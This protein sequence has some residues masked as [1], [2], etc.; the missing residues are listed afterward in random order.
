MYTGSVHLWCFAVAIFNLADIS[1]LFEDDDLTNEQRTKYL[2]FILNN[3]FSELF[4]TSNC[5]ISFYEIEDNY[6]GLFNFNNQSDFPQISSI[7]DS[8]TKI[9]N[10]NFDIDLVYMLSDCTEGIYNISLAYSQ[11]LKCLNHQMFFATNTSVSYSDIFKGSHDELIIFDYQSEQQLTNSIKG[12]DR[13]GALSVIDRIFQKISENDTITLE[14]IKYIIINIL[15]SISKAV[16]N[17]EEN[18]Y[19]SCFLVQECS[20]LNALRTVAIDY[21]NA[22]CDAIEQN[23]SKVKTKLPMDEVIDWTHTHYT[24]PT[25]N[26]SGAANHFNVSPN[27]F[28][29]MFKLSFNVSFID[30]I[31]SLRI[32]RTLELIRTEG[33]P[34]EKAA[35]MSGFTNKRTFYRVRKNFD[36]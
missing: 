2:Q 4:S 15:F 32:E 24:D 6:L 36:R 27:Y 16:E 20:N 8:G 34:V 7:L 35:T 13:D 12:M 26:I 28:S 10:E 5:N 31:N 11:A 33:L 25:L 21:I 3:I 22:T 14:R 1:V 17:D 9:I 19:N 23:Y 29:K 30:Y 18:V